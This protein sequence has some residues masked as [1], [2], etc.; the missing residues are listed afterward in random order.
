MT[1]TAESAMTVR[2]PEP[3]MSLL[4][5]IVSTILYLVALQRYK[6]LAVGFVL[7]ISSPPF[8]C[9]LVVRSCMIAASRHLHD[10]SMVVA[11]TLLE[12]AH[13]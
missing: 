12:E 3:L 8:C 10:R 13:F 6:I 11:A 2:V 9:S 4:L 7:F 5:M 1:E